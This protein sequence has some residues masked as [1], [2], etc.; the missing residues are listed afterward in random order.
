MMKF[1]LIATAIG[2]IACL[3]SNDGRAQEGRFLGNET[4]PAIER[5]L[6]EQ[7]FLVEASSLNFRS[8]PSIAND[9]IGV[10]RQGEPVLVRDQTFNI[11]EQ[12]RWASVRRRD[13]LEGWVA[14]SYL[15][16]LKPVLAS[17]DAA[18]EMLAGLGM[19]TQIAAAG[20]IEPVSQTRQIDEIHAGF[21][22]SAPIGDAG[23]T[24]SHDAGRRAIEQ[25][26]FV[27]ATSY[28]ESVPEDAELIAQA[29]AQ[30][31][32]GG[33]N[34]IFGTSFGYMDAM[35]E[36][37]RQYPDVVFMHS[38]GFKTTDNLG[39]YFGRIY[40]ARYLSGMVAGAA[41]QTGKLGF[42]GAFPIAQLVRG[43]NA[44]T[45]GAQSVNPDVEV[46]VVWTGTW[47]G[48]GIESEAAEELIARGADVLTMHQNSPA[49]VQTAEK[50]GI[51]GVGFHSDMSLFAPN[52]ALTSAAWD[53][54][55]IYTKAVTDLHD[56]NWLADQ[57]W[58]GIDEG[59]VQLAPLNKNLSQ[60]LANEV[61]ISRA[62]LADGTL[63]I[64][65]GP[66]R[67][68]NGDI[69]VPS[70]QLLSDAELL[71]MDFFVMGVN[72]DLPKNETGTGD[73]N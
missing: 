12:R 33:A 36:A 44:F 48:P 40:Q 45:L 54:T 42:V 23:W 4:V 68:Q 14:S 61:E 15:S 25:L 43:I 17:I 39:T 21:V 50:A 60:S 65:E 32:E 41:T 22:Y 37:S 47:Y 16:P 51:K 3:T 11:D 1:S 7:V 58:W 28:I 18:M 63:R 10:L 20:A 66:L 9:P 29:I 53:W 62:K 57:K 49:V 56:G 69:V 46:D 52:A 13:G 35:V 5:S 71:A 64:F 70:G 24:F 67:G 30:L 2:A 8:D 34:L 72:G 59:A 31:I 27:T 38:G 26:P 19:T 55:P 73:D 6:L